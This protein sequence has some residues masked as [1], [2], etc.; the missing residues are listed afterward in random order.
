MK[1]IITIVLIIGIPLGIFGFVQTR[2]QADTAFVVDHTNLSLFDQIPDSF[3]TAASGMSLVYVDRSVGDNVNDGLDCLAYP[4]VAAAPSSCKR[5][6]AATAGL[7][8]NSKYNRSNWQFLFYGTHQDYFNAN[9]PSSNVVGYLPNYL[10][11]SGTS[12]D[13]VF[14]DVISGLQSKPGSKIYFTTSLARIIGTQSSADYDNALRSWINTHGG[15]LVDVADIESHAPNGSACLYN[16]I[17][18]LCQEYTTETDGGH[19]GSVSAG[20]IRI[21]KA[22]WIAMAFK[23]GWNPGSQAPSPTPTS[24]PHRTPTPGTNPLWERNCLTQ[25]VVTYVNGAYQ[26]DCY[27]Q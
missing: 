1:K 12:Q 16:G 15:I 2:V 14:S 10:E 23:A 22:I 5:P 20:K 13:V 7:V 11:F 9:L 21:A 27:S 26:V 17:P 4:S 25:P 19:L 8:A 24:N 3:I 18:N 6:D